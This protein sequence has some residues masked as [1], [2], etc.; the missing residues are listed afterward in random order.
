[1]RNILALIGAVVVLVAAGGWYLGW[2]K[3]STEPGADGHINIK[4]DVDKQKILDD[5]KKAQQ[6]VG[7]I[8]NNQTSG[9]PADQKK[10]QGTTTSLQQN[11][12]GSW[13]I[14]PPK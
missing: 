1:M 2:Y 9:T 10:V 12:D 3:L 13:S 8:I 5:E 7:E 11:A 4:A 14:N 6:K